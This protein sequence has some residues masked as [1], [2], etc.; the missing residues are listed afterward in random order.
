MIKK[1]GT[2][3][4]KKLIIQFWRAKLALAMQ[5]L[6]QEGL[7]KEK[8]DGEIRILCSPKLSDDNVF[9]QGSSGLENSNIGWIKFNTQYDLNAYLHWMVNAITDEL[10]TVK[11]KLEAGEMCEVWDPDSKKWL[12]RRLF[13]V[14]PENYE[15]G[16]IVADLCE[17][18][19]Y[20]SFPAA[21][22]ITKRTEPR[23][24]ENGDVVTYTW[25]E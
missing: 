7:P 6:E 24:E 5:I 25:E 15:K 1:K 18:N 21:R 11:G 3:M 13:A 14:L 9:L 12:K 20:V 10:F 22:A 23:V 8:T 2:N 17:P 16:F 4:S 19:R